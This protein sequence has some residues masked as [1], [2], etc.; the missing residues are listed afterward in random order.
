MIT[1]LILILWLISPLLV[2]L[3]AF[4]LRSNSPGSSHRAPLGMAR[5][6]EPLLPGLR[7][8]HGSG[9]SRLDDV[10]G[11]P[12][13]LPLPL[14]GARGPGNAP[15]SRRG[16]EAGRSGGGQ[17]PPR[18]L[19]SPRFPDRAWLPRLPGPS[20]DGNPVLWREWHRSKPSRFLRVVWFLYSAP[21]SAL[22]RAVAANHERQ[23]AV[24][25]ELIGVM[26]MFQVAVGLL[27]L[28][29]SAATS[30]A[31]ERV[32][33]SLD[34]LLSTPL[35]TRSI[36]AGKWLGSFQHVAHVLVWPAVTAGIPPR[37]ERAVVS[38]ISCCWG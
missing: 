17:V 21:G 3:V 22:D 32:R 38:A 26:N 12:G 19:C 11:V 31:E 2:L 14:R 37:R 29:V 9:Q 24:T 5:V 25:L 4:S 36:L 6:L 1:Y 27:L 23:R 35:S 30:L 8:L 7:A 28:S 10:S 33:G 15:D 20:L 13:S 16:P 34:L 18:P